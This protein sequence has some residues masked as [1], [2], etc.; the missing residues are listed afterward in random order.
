MKPNIH[1]DAKH[2]LQSRLYNSV[3]LEIEKTFVYKS[4]LNCINFREHQNEICGLANQR[5]PARVIVLGC[6]MWE[7]KDEIP[8]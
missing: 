7:D 5:P 2:E 1:P 8:F 4:C 6:R 3:L